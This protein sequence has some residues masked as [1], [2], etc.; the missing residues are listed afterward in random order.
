ML[1]GNGRDDILG[2]ILSLGVLQNFT[3]VHL[4]IFQNRQGNHLFSDHE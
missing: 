2:E 3:L 1:F 4:L